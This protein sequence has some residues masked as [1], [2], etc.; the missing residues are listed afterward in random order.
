MLAVA[1]VIVGLWAPPGLV[2]TPLRQDARTIMAMVVIGLPAS[3]AMLFLR[4][5]S[6]YV[7]LPV[8][9]LVRSRCAWWAIAYV[10][11]TGCAAVGLAMLGPAGAFAG[12]RNSGTLM[13]L[14]TLTARVVAVEWAWM[15]A[16]T[17]TGVSLLFGTQDFEGTASPWALL[18]HSSDSAT[19]AA[20]WVALTV[21]AWVQYAR[22]DGRAAGD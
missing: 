3:L 16:L 7:E 11:V 22:H 18:Q 12:V 2:E 4:R 17:F 5:P 21:V 19:A 14:T 15:P 13:A 10:A 20:I 8:R 1:T 6:R 9:R